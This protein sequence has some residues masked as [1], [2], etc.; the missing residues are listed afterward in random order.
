M[1]AM[2]LRAFAPALLVLSTLSGCGVTGS[3]D[4]LPAEPVARERALADRLAMVDPR[5]GEEKGARF[6][7]LVLRNTSSNHVACRCA[8]QWFDAKGGPIPAPVDWRSVDLKSGAEARLRF[9]PM[10]AEARSWRLRFEG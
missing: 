6:L 5:T 10:P 4:D 9:A 8:P 2:L 3:R 1:P 7:E